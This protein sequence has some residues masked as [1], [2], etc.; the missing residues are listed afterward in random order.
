MKEIWIYA[1]QNH[2]II[3]SSFYEILSKMKSVY[4]EASDKP[5]F[6]AVV[7]GG[8]E[9]AV[10]QLKASGADRILVIRHGKLAEYHP[11]YYAETLYQLAKEQKPEVILIAA[12]AIGAELAPS[13]SAKLDTGLVAHSADICL[14]EN[15][16]LLM[17]VPAFGGKLM[18]EIMIPKARPVM[19]S[20]TPGVFERQEL[21]PA[22][23]V[24]VC[25]CDAGYLDD[26]QTGIE[27]V[28]KKVSETQETPIE[29][30][31]AV[32]CAGLGIGSLENFEKAGE[33]ARL[34][35][36][37]L[38]YTRPVVDVGYAENESAMIGTS[39]KMIRPKLYLGFGVSGAAHHVCGMKDSGLIINVNTNEKADIFQVSNYKVVGDSG[40]ILN[41]LLKALKTQ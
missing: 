25:T 18:G 36:A 20:I 19:A 38:C 23:E 5:R 39:G 1:E 34:L 22:E 31:E 26:L 11:A 2:G 28:D 40:A 8:E 32:V 24:E 4:A 21:A 33:L 35:D 6:T 30:A 3:A 41:E 17:I 16:E 10:S 9:E 7:F 15:E 13:V 37:S 27:L 14:D 29:E 12:S